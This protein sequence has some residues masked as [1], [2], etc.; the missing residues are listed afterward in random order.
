MSRINELQSKIIQLG[1]GAFQKLCD[2]YLIKKY[3]PE[4]F[5]S[6]G[7][8][9]G[10]D[11][12]TKGVPDSFISHSDGKY[13]LMVYGSHSK[14]PK[15]KIKDDILGCL[16]K[17]KLD[18]D[19][20]KIKEII[21]CHAS[22]NLRIEDFEE[23]LEKTKGIK[24]KLIGLDDL[25]RDLAA[26]RFQGIAKDHLNVAIDTG[27]IFSID[28][29]V[30]NYDKGGLASPLDTIFKFRESEINE[31]D[32]AVSKN[33]AVLI[34]GSSGV[35]K[36]RLALEICRK[37]EQLGY[38]VFCVKNNGLSLYEDFRITVSS[39]G[40]YL[41]FFDDMNELTDIGAIVGSILIN[42]SSATEIKLLATVRDYEK[43]KISNGLKDFR[44]KFREIK[45]K[46]FG[47]EEI[48]MILD[49]SLDIKNPT[50]QSR[51]AKIAKGN[52][53][54]AI[55]AGKSAIDNPDSV[56]NAIDIFKS[57]YDPILSKN[58][59]SSKAIKVLFI[60]SL[61][62]TVK[63]NDEDFAKVLLDEFKISWAE[64]E[65]ISRELHYKELITYFMDEIVKINDQSFG[66]YI[67]NYVLIDHKFIR[68][69]KLLELGLSI[70][71]GRIVFAL[72]TIFQLF[73]SEET[74]KY[75]TDQINEQWEKA[76][77]ADQEIFL[78]VFSQINPLKSLIVI[79][80]KIDAMPL[81]D[82]VITD[83]FFDTKKNYQNITDKEIEILS[84]FKYIN[85]F[86][87]AVELMLVALNKER[88]DLFMDVYFG[89]KRFGYDQ[90]SHKFD[91]GKEYDLIDWLWNA[92][93]ESDINFDFLLL[94]IIED[95]LVCLGTSTEVGESA[96]SIQM[97]HFSIIL[98]DGS[99]KLRK[100][101]WET[102]A[103]LYEEEVYRE[104]VSSLLVKYHWSGVDTNSTPIFQYDLNCIKEFFV[105][106]W[107]EPTFDQCLILEK[108]VNYA[109]R[110]GISLEK[111][112]TRY[113]KNDD[114]RYYEIIAPRER[115]EL[116]SNYRSKKEKNINYAVKKFKVSDYEKL[117]IIAKK[118]EK[119][120]GLSDYLIGENLFIALNSASEGIFD[121][122]IQVY[123]LNDAPYP[124]QVSAIISILLKRLS[125]D[126]TYE[127]INCFEFDNKNIWLC[128]IWDNIPEMLISKEYAEL[129]MSFIENQK[130]ERVLAFPRLSTIL[131]FIKDDKTI[132][133]KSIEI[134]IKNSQN[135]KNKG[136]IA[137]FLNEYH[138]NPQEL[139]NVF[140]KNLKVLEK[141]YLENQENYF[142]HGGE[143][144][145]EILERDQSFW[146][147]Y[148]KNIS[149][150]DKL[151][152]DSGGKIFQKIWLQDNYAQ[153]MNIAYD[154]LIVRPKGLLLF[155]EVVKSIF[156]QTINPETDK[157]IKTWVLDYIKVNASE[158]E[159]MNWIFSRVIGYQ[160]EEYRIECV[161]EFLKNNNSFK[162]F[163]QL[164]L[165]PM[166]RGW[167]GSEVPLISR[168]I[169][170]YEELV[171]NPSLSGLNF[172]EHKEYLS[173]HIRSLKSYNKQVLLQ[174]YQ[175]DRMNF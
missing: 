10:T 85:Y 87:E 109:K 45:I 132:I 141:L 51:I 97:M 21:C 27:Q 34:S 168:D 63:V 157:R 2:D 134:L 71:Q 143:I 129:F 139:V 41:I 46:P 82:F 42:Q 174:E 11:K 103:K 120:K 155:S 144:L 23:I 163:Q 13:T 136:L 76:S 133:D 112:F 25:S 123:F 52:I 113:E 150:N 147:E 68:I 115:D 58:A 152:D 36:T 12:P 111:S 153:L 77:E 107:V 127:L 114:Y 158:R 40:R 86:R 55:M 138:D 83:D 105:D 80:K 169:Q 4:N 110:L 60:I 1:G 159:L 146:E 96:D 116:L 122:I 164:H 3:D 28:D 79:K 108:L 70:R 64:F 151:Y 66:N 32:E 99:K 62:G 53:R 128:K 69:S 124:Y 154:I 5:Q 59:L 24:I 166:S 170:F 7:S 118:L 56:R 9:A 121:Q 100:Y 17:N 149:S 54:L 81:G 98:T 88:A 44:E 15:K 89:L 26:I 130:T 140:E 90:H 49:E 161:N 22:T 93:K 73:P 167:S 39:P 43:D 135:S 125:F 29:F 75:L 38:Q 30:K 65:E 117:I 16:D 35:G 57:F 156:P 104:K 47:D 173:E 131:K 92:R 50:F 119:R 84:S 148:L 31:L 61:L 142:D 19:K 94:K 106:S 172:L 48:K 18:I 72:N 162:D 37:Y 74:Q 20:S 78:E 33:A 175:D 126:K 67:L 165:T 95:L 171:Q 14:N 101:L 160:N 8:Q 145:L 102:L 137:M 6:L 91:Y